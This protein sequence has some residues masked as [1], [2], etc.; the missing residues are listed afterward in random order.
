M[1]AFG[2]SRTRHKLLIQ[3]HGIPGR[4]KKLYGLREKAAAGVE[5]HPARDPLR[6]VQAVEASA[7]VAKL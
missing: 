7:C 3:L 6:E 2:S 1:T 5:K 4:P